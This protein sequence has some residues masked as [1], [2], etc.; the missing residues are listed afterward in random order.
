MKPI[1]GIFNAVQC[2]VRYKLLVLFPVLLIMPITLLLAIYWGAN[3]SYDQLF[4]KMN[5]DLTISDNI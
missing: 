2:K 5:T 4:I 1:K 3:F